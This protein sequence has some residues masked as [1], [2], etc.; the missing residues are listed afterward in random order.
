MN[1]LEILNPDQS[2]KV[3]IEG[4]EWRN[5]INFIY[6]SIVDCT[7]P[8]VKNKFRTMKLADLQSA[9]KEA[10]DADLKK[11]ADIALEAA[12][13]EKYEDPDLR[14]ILL[15]TGTIRLKSPVLSCVA[16]LKSATLEEATEL[17]KCRSGLAENMNRRNADRDEQAYIK[18]VKQAIRIKK[19]ILWC[20]KPEEMLA[21]STG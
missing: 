9:T 2:G 19:A 3:T 10:M 8:L 11:I 13:K 12:Y 5:V 21:K 14:A 1:D 16:S 6:S 18:R 4:E 7:D 20:T 15:K 17:M